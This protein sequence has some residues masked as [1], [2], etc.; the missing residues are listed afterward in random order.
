MIE[1]LSTIYFTGLSYT[2]FFKGKK[3]NGFNYKFI[4]R[5][6][7][8]NAIAAMLLCSIAAMFLC[9][10]AAMLLCLIAAM[11]LCSI[12]GTENLFAFIH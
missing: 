6:E 1:H 7:C 11:L 5:V 3:M 10:I 4:L 12:A 2:T 8:K 9:S